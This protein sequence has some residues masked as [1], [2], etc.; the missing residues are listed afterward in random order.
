MKRILSVACAALLGLA[1]PASPA[2]AFHNGF[3]GFGGFHNGVGF[4]NGF[5][6]RNNFGAFNN[7]FGFSNGF[8][9]GNVGVVGLGG[10]GY[11]GVASVQLT[12]PLGVGVFYPPQVGVALPAPVGYCPPA[13]GV[14]QVPLGV[15]TGTYS[16]VGVGVG[17]G[18]GVGVGVGGY[19]AGFGVGLTPGQQLL[20]EQGRLSR[21]AGRIRAGFRR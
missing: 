10:Y 9:N 2:S 3:G 8:Y 13:V 17:V 18:Y 6:F 4:H 5:G 19:G 21:E 1:L 11:G 7:G 12:P 14:A 20:A 15:T 16:P